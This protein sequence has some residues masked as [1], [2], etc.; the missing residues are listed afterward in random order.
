MRPASLRIISWNANGIRACVR[1]GFVDWLRRSRP[2]I[3]GLQ[4]V[5]ALE[6][7][8]PDALRALTGWHLHVSPAARRGYSGVAVLSRRPFDAV[9]TTL[10]DPRFDI[11]GRVQFARCG[12]LCIANVYFPKGSGTAR[13][14][15]RVPYKLDFY[16][17]V[18]DALEPWRRRERVLVLGDFNTAHQP[19]DLARPQANVQNSGFLPEERAELSRWIAAGWVDTFRHFEPGPGHYTWWSNLPGARQRNI[20]WRIDYVLAS[21]AAMPYVQRAFIQPHITGS[22]HCPVGVDIDAAMLG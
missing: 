21:P 20:G 13:D 2:T 1:K 18:F 4:E 6:A 9:H 14:N 19:I 22:D 5:R 10:G 11:E 15:S 7:E 8:V 12:R 3:V 17:R 16:R